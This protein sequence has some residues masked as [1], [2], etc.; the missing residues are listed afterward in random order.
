MNRYD[1]IITYLSQFVSDSKKAKFSAVC[2]QRTRHVTVVLEDLYQTHNMSAA[3]RSIEA[4]GVQDVH[5]IE[6][7]NRFKLSSSIAKGSGQWLTVNRYADSQ[8]CLDLLRAQGYVIVAT[9]MHPTAIPLCTLPINSKSALV[10][11]T[12]LSGVSSQ[13]MAQADM[14]VTIP[15]VGFTQS[16]NVS[17]AV[18]LCLYDLM[19]RLRQSDIDW[20]LSADEVQDVTLAW[21]RSSIDQVEKCERR[22]FEQKK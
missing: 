13:V 19:T 9:S 14:Y 11:G 2:A 18:G 10:F 16:F 4:L 20:R 1:D 6:K 22:F 21:L 5:V 12:E 3:F 17:V 8:A 15:M 7:H